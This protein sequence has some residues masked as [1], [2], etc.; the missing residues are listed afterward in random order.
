MKKNEGIV[1]VSENEIFAGNQSSEK[2]AQKSF[3]FSIKQE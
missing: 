3:D 2:H 1:I